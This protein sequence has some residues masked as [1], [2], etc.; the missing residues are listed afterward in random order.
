MLKLGFLVSLCVACLIFNPPLSRF[1][2]K[3]I[4]LKIKKFKTMFSCYLLKTIIEQNT[5]ALTL[6]FISDSFNE[7]NIRL[8]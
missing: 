1:C 5:Y 4:G 6:I 3:P 2:P 7:K 8:I